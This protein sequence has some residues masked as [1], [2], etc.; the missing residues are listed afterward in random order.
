ML[1]PDDLPVDGT[2]KPDRH[3]LALSYR[4]VPLSIVAPLRGCKADG[5]TLRSEGDET[6][7]VRA[8]ALFLTPHRNLP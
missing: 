2:E 3:W 4:L 5:L 8:L 7:V 1:M 6:V